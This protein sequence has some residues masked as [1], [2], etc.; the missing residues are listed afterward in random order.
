MNRLVKNPALNLDL[1][2]RRQSLLQIHSLLM[3][4]K[5]II[6]I[7]IGPKL[8]IQ[9]Q[10]VIQIE[11]NIMQDVYECQPFLIPKFAV[12]KVFT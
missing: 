10:N 3:W 5:Q 6:I 1:Q 2:S 7:I 9:D 8:I 12:A 4:Q 11:S